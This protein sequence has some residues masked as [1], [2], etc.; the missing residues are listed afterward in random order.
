MTIEPRGLRNNNPGNLNFAHQTG[1]VLEY[2]M[3]HPRFARFQTM[4][5]GVEALCQQLQLYFQRHINT[6][7]G[8]ICK[9][10]PPTENYTSAYS[11]YVAQQMAV[12]PNLVL[13]GT[14]AQAARLALAIIHLENGKQPFTYAHVLAAAEKVWGHTA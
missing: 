3:A 5:D 10:A 14:P 4:D 12:D 7:A 1:A 11:A 8:I 6:V 2:G 9:W 13:Q